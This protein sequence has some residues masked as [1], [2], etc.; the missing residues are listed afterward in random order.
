MIKKILL[1]IFI[2][3]T[4]N[5]FSGL[6]DIYWQNIVIDIA[7]DGDPKDRIEFETAV[8]ALQNIEIQ[9]HAIT[10]AK[11]IYKTWGEDPKN[12]GKNKK[13]EDIDSEIAKE[14]TLV[15]LT[16]LKRYPHISSKELEIEVKTF[17]RKPKI[18]NLLLKTQ[19]TFKVPKDAEN[20]KEK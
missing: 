12:K 18:S 6:E 11:A 1:I 13:G 20:G 2:S 10:A 3:L 8:N 7:N 9:I 14:A 16:A 15:T 4:S 17:I 19:I 5:L